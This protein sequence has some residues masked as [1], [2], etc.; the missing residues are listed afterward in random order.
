MDPLLVLLVVMGGAVIVVLIAYWKQVLS[1][2]FIALI[3]WAVLRD[4]DQSDFDAPPPQ[5]QSRFQSPSRQPEPSRQYSSP[6]TTAAAARVPQDDPS[7]T[8][9][10]SAAGEPPAAARVSWVTYT[11]LDRYQVRSGG[12]TQC[13]S[14]S[15]YSSS[16]G[17][18]C[19][20]AE[21]CCPSS[22]FDPSGRR[23]TSAPVANRDSRRSRHRSRHRYDEDEDEDDDYSYNPNINYV[24]SY[25]RRDGTHVDGHWR[26]NPDDRLDNNLGRGNGNAPYLPAP[27]MFDFDD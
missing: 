23:H 11:C 8:Y 2:A 7:Y 22:V 4:S 6:A 18:G 19:P 27:P 3:I 12:W 21:L 15:A 5:Q 20:G 1:I 14:R 13:L 10:G 24:Q 17:T 26:S 9:C 16:S 25:T